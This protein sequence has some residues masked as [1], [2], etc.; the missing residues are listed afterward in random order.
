[1]EIVLRFVMC[2]YVQSKNFYFKKGDLKETEM[3]FYTLH[4]QKQTSKRCPLVAVSVAVAIPAGETVNDE[5]VKESNRH[6]QRGREGDTSIFCIRAI[7]SVIF[8]PS[9]LS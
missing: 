7:F 2:S 9:H 3:Q 6:Y 5:K 4:V 1:M 8:Q